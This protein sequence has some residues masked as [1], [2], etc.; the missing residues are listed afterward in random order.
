[1]NIFYTSHC[2]VEC[3]YDL[4]K[5]LNNKMIVEVAQILSTAHRE[6]D[7]DVF[8]DE[9]GLYRATHR[10]HPCAVFVR[11]SKVCYEWAHLHLEAML[12]RFEEYSGKSHK[13]GGVSKKLSNAPKNISN[14]DCFEPALAVPEYFKKI[15]Q[16]KNVPTAY[17]AYLNTKFAE[18]NL[19]DKPI[20][21]E[22]PEGKP[23]WVNFENY[24]T[25]V[26]YL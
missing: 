8:A 1:M 6:L 7:G 10:N 18:W 24:T 13:S 3:A 14:T 22:W 4:P 21:T 26:E 9:V 16:A 5:V 2:P 20:K 11:R 12:E 17:R 19:R 25:Y 15:A 23:N